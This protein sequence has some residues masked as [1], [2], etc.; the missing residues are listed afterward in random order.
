MNRTYNTLFMLTSVDGKIS[1]GSTDNL[2][3]DQDLP[4]IV[5]AKEG[6]QQCYDIEKTTDFFSFNTGRVMAKVGWNNSKEEI[7]KVTCSFVIVDNKP[8]LTRLGVENLIAKTEK[9]YIVTTNKNHPGTDFPEAEVIFYEDV[10]DFHDLFR[11]LKEVYGAQR[12]TVQSGGNMNA[13]LLRKGLIDAVSVVVAPILVG[14]NDTSTLI[15]GDSLTST[16]DVSKLR[17]L[18]VQKV[19][20]LK[21]S[22][23]HIEYT[24]NN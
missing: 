12:V 21:D 20:M 2:D 19:A 1:T 4:A 9:L 7:D 23:L 5:G 3:F 11:R 24:V 18:E 15:D 14:G 17:T 6:L 22:Y 8:H 10:I 13:L 16:S